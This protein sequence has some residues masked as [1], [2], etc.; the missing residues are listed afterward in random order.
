M[1]TNV[2][3]GL[4]ISTFMEV[5]LKVELASYAKTVVPVYHS[6]L[7]YTPEGRKFQLRNSFYLPSLQYPHQLIK[8]NQYIYI[9]CCI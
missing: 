8:L 9:I 6:T 7:C 1:D 3:Q 4:S 2:S 5:T